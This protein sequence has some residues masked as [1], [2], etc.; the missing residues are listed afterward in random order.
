MAITIAAGAVLLQLKYLNIIK[1]IYYIKIFNK[2]IIAA[3]SLLRRYLG[4]ARRR[5]RDDVLGCTVISSSRC[6]WLNV[7]GTAATEQGC[8]HARVGVYIPR[9]S[10]TGHE[11][12]EYYLY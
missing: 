5:F 2:T 7:I 9:V 6:V 4:H 10:L 3:L 1:R 11:Q 12:P 8:D